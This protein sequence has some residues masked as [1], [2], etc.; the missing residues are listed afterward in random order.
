MLW[1]CRRFQRV[2]AAAWRAGAEGRSVP[3]RR[4]CWWQAGH[5]PRPVPGTR[6]PFVSRSGF[7]LQI[8]QNV[9]VRRVPRR[10][11]SAAV[12]VGRSYP[13]SR[14]PGGPIRSSAVTA[15]WSVAAASVMSR[16]ARS[17]SARA[18]FG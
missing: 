3:W 8:A 1:F 7:I 15:P 12:T 6:R 5:R 13:L 10:V 14:E 4:Q 16:V 2:F 9:P 18:L 17:A 11:S